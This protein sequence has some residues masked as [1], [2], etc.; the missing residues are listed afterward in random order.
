MSKK[1][2]ELLNTYLRKREISREGNP[3]AYEYNDFE[4]TYLID[5]KLKTFDDLFERDE[6]NRF[7]VVN[8]L[9]MLALRNKYA[10]PDELFEFENG[11]TVTGGGIFDENGKIYYRNSVEFIKKL[12]EANGDFTKYYD[13]SNY[14]E[15]FPVDVDINTK[16]LVGKNGDVL[17]TF[18]IIFHYNER[19]KYVG[20]ITK[21]HEFIIYDTTNNWKLIRKYNENIHNFHLNGGHIAYRNNK[22]NKYFM[23]NLI[24]KKR[25]PKEGY[26]HQIKDTTNLPDEIKDV[27]IQYSKYKETKIYNYEENGETKYAVKLNTRLHKLVKNDEGKYRFKN[28]YD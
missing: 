5:N 22:D 16:L 1:K 8:R 9:K 7:V 21:K 10:K 24:E 26:F 6:N 2:K 23:E 20:G 18:A 3:R 15:Y 17:N 14:G 12:K 11:F 27:I 28:I 13:F 4:I 25:F 19:T